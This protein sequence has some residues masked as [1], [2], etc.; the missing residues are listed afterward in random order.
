MKPKLRVLMMEGPGD[1]LSVFRA[2]RAGKP[3]DGVTHEPFSMQ[4][5]ELCREL[6]ATAKVVALHP[7]LGSETDGNITVEHWGHPLEGKSGLAYHLA[8]AKLAAR[9]T[10]EALAMKA[11]VVFIGNEP[12]PFLFAPLAKAGVAVV[13]A[14]HCVL[15]PQFGRPSRARRL[16]FRADAPFLRSQAKAVMAVSDT[17]LDQVESVAGHASSPLVGFIP[18]FHPNLF[19]G[20]QPPDPSQ[21]PFRVIF[22]ARVEEHKG[23]FD[24]IEVARMLRKD[25]RNVVF[26][27]CGTGSAFDD[28]KRRVEQLGLGDTIRLLG[29]CD[30]SAI[31][32]AFARSHVVLVP[33]TTQFVEGFNMVVVEGLL[34]GRPVVTS[35]VC[36]AIEYVQ[37]AVYE[38]PP[39]DPR[40]YAN[41]VAELMDNRERYDELAR[42]SRRCARRFTDREWGYQSALRHV[43]T[44]IADGRRIT[45]RRL[46]RHMDS[47]PV[48][49]AQA[50]AATMLSA[51]P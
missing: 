36:P 3:F 21:G 2:W 33:T 37:D 4:F 38:V 43:L 42:N 19:D 32:A 6:N 26:E 12:H 9:I 48:D 28:A 24:L 41:A 31:H 50:R 45:E 35:R 5:F 13:P 16:L 40:A 34:A 25:G 14:Y 49:R 10:R 17:I 51:S 30:R 46:R 22:V 7:E 47:Q 23:I 8:H 15:W 20:I 29:W 1:A 44:S 18:S 27:V 11:D 39:D